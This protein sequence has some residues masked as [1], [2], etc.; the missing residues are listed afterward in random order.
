MRRL[1]I[2]FDVGTKEYQNYWYKHYRNHPD[3]TK[4]VL[5]G[6]FRT[7]E[8]QKRK[9][10]KKMKKKIEVETICKYRWADP[11]QRDK[12]IY[13]D[14]QYIYC[15]DFEIY[16]KLCNK[17]NRI[18][19]RHIIPFFYLHKDCY[20]SDNPLFHLMTLKCSKSGKEYVKYQKYFKSEINSVKQQPQKNNHAPVTMNTPD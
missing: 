15:T 19:E 17:Y 11:P 13:E 3:K 1:Q 14:K 10:E 5:D 2:P 20:K 16:S 6:K 9:K 4:Y 12:I 8:L 7:E 18:I